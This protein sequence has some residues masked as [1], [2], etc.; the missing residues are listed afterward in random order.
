MGLFLQKKAPKARKN[1][2]KEAP[3]KRFDQSNQ[4]GDVENT[5]KTKCFPRLLIKKVR[6]CMEREPKQAKQIKKACSK[7][8]TPL[9]I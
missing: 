3:L 4:K 1:D 9:W 2:Q 5:F 7:L 8:I 6:T